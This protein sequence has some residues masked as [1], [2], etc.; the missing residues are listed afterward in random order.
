MKTA[1]F[2]AVAL[3]SAVVQGAAAQE[4]VAFPSHAL[5]PASGRPV[6]IAGVLY[7]PEGTGRFA[8]V[9]GLHGC[10][11]MVDRNGRLFSTFRAWAEHLRGHGYVVLLV[12]SFTPRDLR[13]VCG[14]GSNAASP[15][16]VRPY[17]AYGALSYLEGLRFVNPDRV[18][19]MGWSHGGGSVLYTIAPAT[20]ARPPPAIT[21]AE[22][23]GAIALYPAWCRST[24]MGGSWRPIVPLLALLGAADDW[25]PALPCV[26]FLD[27]VKRRGG[28]VEYHIYPEARHAFD[29]LSTEVRV[30]ENVQAGA[31]GR[32]PSVGGNAAA[33]TDA[34]ARVLAFLKSEL[35]G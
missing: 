34:Y 3:W 24:T 15:S 17:D 16:Q 33:R 7:R 35:G 11:G 21:R 10:S 13:E 19:L 14:Q 22:F 5:D 12:D 25:T 29:M 23:K 9:V 6:E 32:A 20:G 30:L 27:G 26:E 2:L 18:A 28:A 8:A 4:K 1:A 31:S